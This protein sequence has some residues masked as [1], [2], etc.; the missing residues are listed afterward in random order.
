LSLLN[1]IRLA[2]KVV[3]HEVNKVGLVD[4]FGGSG[5]I[6]VQGEEQEKLG[7]FVNNIFT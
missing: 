1:V 5:D 6:N 2:A 4:L 3:N 7:V